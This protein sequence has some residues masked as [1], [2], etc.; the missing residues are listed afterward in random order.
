MV[1]SS[2]RILGLVAE[3]DHAGHAVSKL[4]KKRAFLRGM[5]RDYDMTIEA[6]MCLPLTYNG[7]ASKVIVQ[8]SRL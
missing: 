3:L 4:E 1:E 6:I 5:P 7:A 2:C 8:E